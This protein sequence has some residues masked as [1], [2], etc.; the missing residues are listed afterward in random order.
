M[1]TSDR[2]PPLL[3]ILQKR[4]SY[5]QLVRPDWGSSVWR[6]DGMQDD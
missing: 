3:V 5:R 2:P 6:T 4:K 1:A